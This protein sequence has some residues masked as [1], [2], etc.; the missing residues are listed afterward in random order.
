[1][2]RVVGA[3]FPTLREL[4]DR[5]FV[6]KRNVFAKYVTW[7]STKL[8]PKNKVLFYVSR[9]S[10]E[11]VGEGKIEE[12]YFLT[13]SEALEKYGNRLFLNEEELQEYT[14]QRPSRNASKRMLVLVLSNLTRYSKPHRFRKPITVAGQYLTKA[15][16][17]EL[18]ART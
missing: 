5:M 1:M 14:L 2:R 7:N 13:P 12:I 16:Y 4:V 10:K 8:K 15:E 18:L 3:V 17:A 9:S 6:E 11:I